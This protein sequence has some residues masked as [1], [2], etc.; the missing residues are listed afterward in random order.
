MHKLMVT[1]TV[2]FFF[3]LLWVIYMADT[4]QKSILFELVK[5]TPYGDKIGH[6]VLFGLLTLFINSAFRFRTFLLGKLKLFWGTIAVFIFATVEELSQ[7]FF[8]TRTL[9]FYDFSASILGVLLFT[10]VTWLL[11]NRTTSSSQVSGYD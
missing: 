1:I 6:L 10:W 4:G 3:F 5:Q 7:Y 11:A 8:P 2:S 9:D